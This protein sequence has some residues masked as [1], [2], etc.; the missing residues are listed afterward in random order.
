[1]KKISILL[2]TALA[3]S[4]CDQKSNVPAGPSTATA[5]APATAAP[6]S[7]A[8]AP[9]PTKAAEVETVQLDMSTP[10]RALKSYWQVRDQIR[11]K[12]TLLQ[13][14]RLQESI[15][16]QKQLPDVATSALTANW[17]S[18]LWTPETFTRDIMEVKLES[19]SRAI[20]IVNMKNSTP[21]PAGA[22]IEKI[23]E[24][25]R[26]NGEN[27]RYVLEKDQQGWKVA[28]I[29]EKP[30]Y[31]KTWSKSYPKPNKPFVGALTYTGI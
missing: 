3:L 22:E 23:E 25:Y 8:P 1:M 28:E 19:E 27:Y 10:D 30:S 13:N 9:A 5:T 17:K 24:N 2:L 26:R 6:A 31:Q 15:D 21:I 4:A 29:W 12:D 11:T 18:K 20:I 7:S 14:A 16:Q